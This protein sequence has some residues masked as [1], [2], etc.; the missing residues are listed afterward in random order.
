MPSNLNSESM[1]HY[2]IM[3]MTYEPSLRVALGRSR[4][5][6]CDSFNVDILKAKPMQKIFSH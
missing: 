1:C 3:Y 6:S 2:Q 5:I 4:V